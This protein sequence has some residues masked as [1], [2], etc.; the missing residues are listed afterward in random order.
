MGRWEQK[1]GKEALPFYEYIKPAGW[2]FVSPEEYLREHQKTLQDGFWLNIAHEIDW[3]KRPE[4]ELEGNAPFFRWFPDGVLNMSY[5]CVDM[6]MKARKN[7]VAFFWVGENGESRTLT[8]FDYYRLVNSLAYVMKDKLGLRKGDRVTLYMPM[9]PELPAVMIALARIGVIFSVVFSGFSSNALHERIKDSGSKVVFTAD[10]YFRR[11]K[12][13]YMKEKVMEAVEGTNVENVVI[14]RRLGEG[15]DRVGKFNGINYIFVD[16]LL[17]QSQDT[18]VSP[19]EVESYHPLFIL[20]TS[21]TTGKPKGIVRDTGGYAVI[22]HA[23]MKWVFDAREDDIYWCAADIGW[24]TGHSYIVFGPMMEGLTSVMYEGVPDYPHPGIW[25][26]IVQRFGVSIFYTSPTAIR[27]LMGYSDEH[28]RKYDLRSLRILHS[29]GEP[30]NPEAWWWYY[31]KV[32]GECCPVG[33][34][35]WMTET[36]GVMISHTPGWKLV[37]LKP[38]T[39]ALA[40]PGVAVDVLRADGKRAEDGERGYLVLTKPWPGMPL[41]IWCEDERYK[42]TYWTKF[43]HTN[44]YTGD[45]AIRDG[46]GYIWV[47]GRADEVMNVAGH[48][49]GTYEIESALVGHEGVVE[50]AVISAEDK[51][52]GEVP[53]AFV[54]VKEGVKR[55]DELKNKLKDEVKKKIG[56]IAIPRD[57]VFVSKLPKTRSGKIMRRLL[58]AV[59]SGKPLGDITT[60]EDE[61]S[62]I[63][64]EQEYRELKKEIEN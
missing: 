62:V 38:G 61:A 7:K 47:L 39:N 50:A 8:Y 52:K 5:L 31:E 14:F 16:D 57:I 19:I 37:P 63:E 34:T 56:P 60:L 12:K 9:I 33:S 29:V 27:L 11:G 43:G 25:W 18:Y 10:G 22:L 4:R 46:D 48:R 53:V 21:G 55:S 13:I 3:F 64:I 35:W 40:I 41:T 44:F 59:L 15:W 49:L 28:V 1:E 26:E 42:E 17:A 32:G 30:I 6:H 45:Y 23:T 54:V 2:D 36:G 24:I 20:Y 51:V 58:K